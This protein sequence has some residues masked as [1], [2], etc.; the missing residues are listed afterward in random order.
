[1]FQDTDPENLNKGP[2]GSNPCPEYLRCSD[3]HVVVVVDFNLK[4]VD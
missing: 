3:S 4:S 1:L 2:L